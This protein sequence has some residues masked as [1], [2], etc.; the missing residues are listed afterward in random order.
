MFFAVTPNNLVNLILIAVG[1]GVCFMCIIQITSSIH[2]QVNV[3]RYFQFFFLLILLYV[4][5][6][7]ARQLM[8]GWPGEKIRTALRI[9]TFVE[10]QFAG[11]MAF[12]MSMLVLEV[13]K[14]GDKKKELRAILITIL[15]IHIAIIIVGL[16]NRSI[17]YFDDGNYYHRSKLYLLSNV[18]PFIMLLYNGAL[19]VCY[20]NNI[21]SKVRKAF[22]IYII[23]PILAIIIQSSTYDIQ[24]IIFATVFA[25]VYMFFVIT[26]NL[27]ERYELQQQETARIGTELSMATDIQAS[28]LPRLFPA[29][30]NRSEFDLY[31]SM[32]PAK[33]V[34][35]DF[36]DFFLIDDNHL[37]LVMADVSGKGIPAA[38]F[39]MISRVLIK[40]HLQNGESPGEAL[41]NVNDQLCD[42]NDA[43]LFVTVWLAVLEISTGKVVSAN[44]GHE[45]P[46]IYRVGKKYEL[47]IYKHSPALAMLE[48]I[49]FKEQSFT[50]KPGDSIFVYTDGVPEATNID[51]ELFGTDRMLN[52]LNENSNLTP[53]QVLTNVMNGIKRFVGDAEQFDDITML[54][55]RY[56]GV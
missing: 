12:M 4:S 3:R 50:L 53:E 10:M 48:N 52:V 45:H 19:L 8:D 39:M 43:N 20:K 26:Q 1:I 6:H 28:Q 9:V 21:N 44:A 29:F 51:K 54:C 25:A 7:L 23:A 35:G 56:Q 37:G 31:A 40:T 32:T 55:L 49:T 42:G 38:L 15:L 41:K 36:Y 24:F 5:A 47:D 17:Y 30:P 13:S 18:C 27:N 34:G 46:A 16:F 33:E 11:F 22:W 14:V 2:L